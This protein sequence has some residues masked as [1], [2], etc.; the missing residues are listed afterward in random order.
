L[1]G[2]R[3][4][5]FRG[6][7]AAAGDEAAESAVAGAVGGPEDDRRGVG[8]RDLGADHQRQA[9]VFGGDV[10]SHHSGQAVAIGHRQRA[11]TQRGGLAHQLIGVRCAFEEGEV[12]L[13]FARRAI[14]TP[15]N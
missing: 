11:V 10:C 13:L 8:R 4:L 2:E 15:N 12:R 3:T 6:L 1:L 9:G 14:L 7:A 5:A